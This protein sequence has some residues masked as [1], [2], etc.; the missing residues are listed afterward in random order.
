MIAYLGGML[1]V[2]LLPSLAHAG[3]SA[4]LL[5]L[6]PF[7]RL[8]RVILVYLLGV[9]VASLWGAWQ[10]HHR[11]PS[12]VEAQDLQVT[13]RIES[14]VQR[15]GQRQ[16]F[17]LAITALASERPELQRLRRVRLSV[18]RSDLRFGVGDQI[19]AVVRLRSPRGLH[20]PQARDTERYYLAAGIDARG[21]LRRLLQHRP[22]DSRSVGLTRQWIKRGLIERFEA[23]TANTLAALIIGDRSGLDAQHWEWLRRT[24]TAH[25]MVV[26]GLHIAV[27]ATLGWLLGRLIAM[28]L[29]LAG[30]MGCGR[31]LPMAFALTSATAYAAL[32]GWGLPVQRAWLML[33]VFLLGN[34]RLLSL[35]GWQRLKFSLLLVVSLQ[36]LAI[37]EPGLWLSF[38]AVAL[39]LWQLQQR[40]Q[41]PFTATWLRLPGE[42]WRLQLGLFVGMA[43]VLV[44]NFHQLSP[45]GIVVNLI[46]VP[47]MSI[48]V[49]SLPPLF[50][51]LPHWPVAG[52]LLEWNLR[53]LWALLQWAAQTPGLLLQVGQPTPLVLALA[54]V[55]T[56]ILLLPLPLRIRAIALLP[57]LPLLL[58]PVPQPSQGRFDVWVFDVG[59]GEAVLIETAQGRLLYDTGPG[60]GE[61]RSAFPYTV[62]PY[63]RSLGSPGLEWVV[64]SHADTDHSGGFTALQ[65]RHGIGVVL[66]PAALP[67]VQAQGCRRGHWQSGGVSFTLLDPF[68][69]HT[70]LSGNDRSCVL[71]VSNGHCSL[72]L[73]GDLSQRGEYRL[74]SAGKIE[75]VTWLMAGHHGSRESTTGALLDYARPEHVLISAGF[76]NR[77][78][79]PHQEVIERIERRHIPWS[80]TAGRGALLLQAGSDSCSLVSH[81]ALK[82]RYW[83]A[84]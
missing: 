67:G 10:L 22:A 18:Y 77:F 3:L 32:A 5:F 28:P 34:G 33:A 56:L 6:L 21:Y 66:S 52:A 78:G 42:W 46:A 72:L 47:W 80:S 60:F 53:Q 4:L 61:G 40:R 29:Q 9:A 14:L 26:S 79:H 20:N 41:P 64:V 45:V 59:Q 71:R 30:W 58:L 7:T 19:R 12:R 54:L 35:S 15:Q 55:G 44:L 27:M 51:L 81:R 65:Q 8:R 13:G 57:C 11:L 2:A 37:L 69:E 25:L 70:N 23:Q 36:P 73:T 82:K 50:A 75:P 38:G 24:G 39:I 83:T 76:G 48:T 84:G 17:D 31:W 16:V 63:L 68:R 74:L 1:T 62:E 43:L 49:W